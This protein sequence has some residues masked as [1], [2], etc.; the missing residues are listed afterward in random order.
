MNVKPNLRNIPQIFSTGN[1][2]LLPLLGQD[3]E[4]NEIGIYKLCL[5]FTVGNARAISS[6][7]I[8]QMHHDEE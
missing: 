8:R 7:T 3:E 6:D 1:P 5:E 4:M 2:H